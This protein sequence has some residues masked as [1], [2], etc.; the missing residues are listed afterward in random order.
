MEVEGAAEVEARQAAHNRALEPLLGGGGGGGG[1]PGESSG[2]VGLSVSAETASACARFLQAHWRDGRLE[3]PG[4]PRVGATN[5]VG[6][7][8]PRAPA[9]A[10]SQPARVTGYAHYDRTVSEHDAEQQRRNTLL[11]SNALLPACRRQVPGFAAMEQSLL[12]WVQ[13]HYR[14]TV[15]LWYAHALRQSAA[16]LRSS[17]FAV[18]QDTEDFSFIEY[19]VLVKLTP[20]APG[21]PPSA[22]RVVGA[23]HPFLYDAV[24]GAAGCFRADLFHA[25]VAPASAEE[26]LKLAFFF[27]KSTQAERRAKRALAETAEGRAP[28]EPRAQRRKAAPCKEEAEEAEEAEEGAVGAA[29]QGSG[30][31]AAPDEPAPEMDAPVAMEEEAAEAA[32]AEA[33]GTAF[34]PI[35]RTKPSRKRSQ[36][37][38]SAA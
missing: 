26:H 16:T 10:A 4:V 15:E 19:T 36:T 32:E 23:A 9:D 28:P 21:E 34:L 6:G 3:L 5:P 35:S 29:V 31:S 1:G 13:A 12:D 11:M 33:T 25:S 14:T 20:D 8:T 30:A 17:V 37:P 38:P 22:M 24:A 27:R 7:A 18:H 2:V